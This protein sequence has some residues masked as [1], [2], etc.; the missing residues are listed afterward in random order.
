MPLFYFLD[1]TP[2]E[3]KAFLPYVM[4]AYTGSVSL[5]RAI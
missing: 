1:A 2:D 4:V 5:S 3:I